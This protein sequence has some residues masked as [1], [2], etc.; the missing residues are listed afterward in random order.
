[1]AEIAILKQLGHEVGFASLKRLL[2][3]SV[4]KIGSFL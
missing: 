3:L 1:M 4:T 2:L